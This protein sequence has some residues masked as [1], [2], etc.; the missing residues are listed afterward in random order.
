MVKYQYSK[1]AA[2][3]GAVMGIAVLIPS[4]SF[5]QNYE[6]RL[7]SIALNDIKKW[8]QDPVIVEA[9]KKANQEHYNLALVEIEKLDKKWQL[10]RN[11]INQPLIK[12]ITSNEL[13]DF[14]RRKQQE[15]DGLYREIVVMDDRGLV[16]GES[17]PTID[18]W[19]GDEAQW[20]NTFKVGINGLHIGEVKY[21]DAANAF[22]AKVSI[23]I[24]DGD[25]PIGAITVGIDTEQFDRRGNL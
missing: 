15:S 17:I 22:E 19:Q 10:E 9:L 11:N 1:R 20:L 2:I 7:K 8:A 25:E 12:K 16:A 21:D 13:S 24:A 4:L 18:Y 23:T 5:A 14:L 3:M 6:E